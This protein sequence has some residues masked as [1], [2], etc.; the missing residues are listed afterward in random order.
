MQTP[1]YV[2]GN[3][4]Q[5]NQ[6]TYQERKHLER[7]PFVFTCNA[8]LEH[9]RKI[10]VRPTHWMMGDS[11]DG[12]EHSCGIMERQLKVI[13]H[14]VE[15]RD[16]LERIFICLESRFAADMVVKYGSCGLP[17]TLY[18][19]G[20]H[21]DFNQRWASSF[22][23]PL[24]HLNTMLDLINAATILNP[25]GEVRIAGCQRGCG[26]GHFYTH[27]SESQDL[28]FPEI[29]MWEAFPVIKSHVRIVD[30]NSWHD[31]RIEDVYGVPRGSILKGTG[32]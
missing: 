17:I 32:Q 6:L 4:W 19:L 5:L 1:S 27:R 21:I 24:Y 25:G 11:I 14:D 15:L 31:S 20:S 26:G 12:D 29:R 3:S 28:E 18:S 22:Y 8:F 23:Q 7:S 16:R 9:W 2:L 30:C 10:G 13:I